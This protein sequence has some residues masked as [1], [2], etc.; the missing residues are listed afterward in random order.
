MEPRDEVWIS[1][2]KPCPSPDLVIGQRLRRLLR[3]AWCH[4][5]QEPFDTA[6]FFIELT[7]GT[8][9]NPCAWYSH[10]GQVP[11]DIEGLVDASGEL[12]DLIKL[13]YDQE[14]S[15]VDRDR[16][17]FFTNGSSLS[18]D[19]SH[20]GCE[21]FCDAAKMRA[22]SRDYLAPRVLQDYWGRGELPA[23]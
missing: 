20:C 23:K 8:L 18:I 4:S 19:M 11:E 16:K 17:F 22:A 10:M 14:I 15:A 7:S 5:D 9:L 6:D 12:P 13:I 2:D 3:T 1:L 21:V